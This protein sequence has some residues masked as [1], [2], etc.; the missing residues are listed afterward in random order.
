MALEEDEYS[1]LPA[2]VYARGF[3]RS[4]AG[5]LGLDAKELLP[6]FPVGHV[7]E[8]KLEPLPKV[9]APRVY[10]T[11]FLTALAA[12][13]L[14]VLALAGLYGF[15]REG[16]DTLLRGQAETAVLGEEQSAK[17]TTSEASREVAL[18]DLSGRNLDDAV[19]VIEDKGLNYVVVAIREPNVPKG[20]VVEQEPAP[21]TALAPG[22]VVTLIISR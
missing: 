12:V 17:T 6:F 20:W 2:P 13:G 10:S 22:E 5:Y 9:T 15:G 1:L 18:G 7:D 8:P 19:S 3:L 14:L 4:Y 11:G 16:G 21:G